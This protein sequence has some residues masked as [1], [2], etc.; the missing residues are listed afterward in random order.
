MPP[1]CFSQ[2]NQKMMSRY[3]CIVTMDY[4]DKSDVEVFTVKLTLVMYR[5]E[6]RFH[7]IGLIFNSKKNCLKACC[8]VEHM[9]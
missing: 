6:N 2:N 4:I 3:I 9:I 8:F 7:S 5:T 1:Y